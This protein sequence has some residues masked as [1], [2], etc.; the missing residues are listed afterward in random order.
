MPAS[1]NRCRSCSPA[2][3]EIKDTTALAELNLAGVA[4]LLTAGFGLLG[5]GWL[6]GTYKQAVERTN[7]GRAG[8]RE[9]QA[10][11]TEKVKGGG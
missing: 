1:S 2:A 5:S 8:L 11:A 3:N 9:E 10:A 6:T 7:E 4:P